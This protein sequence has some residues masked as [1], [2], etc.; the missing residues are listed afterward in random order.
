MKFEDDLNDSITK[1]VTVLQHDSFLMFVFAAF[2]WE[3]LDKKKLIEM[4]TNF[5]SVDQIL[6]VH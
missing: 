6:D 3:R 2:T 4:K 5:E 1:N